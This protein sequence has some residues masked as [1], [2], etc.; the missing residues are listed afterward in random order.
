LALY[1]VMTYQRDKEHVGTLAARQQGRVTLDQLR[2]LGVSPSTA[3]GWEAQGYLERTLPHVYAVGHAAPNWKADLWA[4]VLYAGP[5]AMLSHRT[6]ARWLGLIDYAPRHIEVST[7]RRAR[8]LQRIKVYARR[9]GLVRG[10]HSGIPVTS[11]SVTMVD[12]AAT[13]GE[14]VVQRALG[15]LD[16]QKLLDVEA[17]LAECRSGRRGAVALRT[18]IDAYDPRRKYANGRLEEDFYAFCERRGLPLPLLN[19]YV[20]DIKCDAYW[21]HQGLVVELDSELGHS[22]P[23]QR[24][25]DRRNDIVLRGHGLTVIRYDWDLVHEQP[26]EVCRDV[27]QALERLMAE[28]RVRAS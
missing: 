19:T 26:A 15:Q 2:R 16:F 9:S 25:R 27:L 13:S 20:H 7:P 6:A 24:R 23:G 5:G 12:L 14:R 18:A 22:S 28:R 21:P 11:I 17:L 4:A 10:L 1:Y 8:S 3:Q